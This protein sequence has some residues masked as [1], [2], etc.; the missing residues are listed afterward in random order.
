[1]ILTTQQKIDEYTSKGWWGT[2][3]VL[4]YF[5]TLV[6]SAPNQTAVIDP[7]NKEQLCQSEKQSYTFAQLNDKVNALAAS[8][9]AQGIRKDDI[10][11]VQ[12]PNIAELVVSYLAILKIGAIA[13][14]FP[15]Q[16]REYE[17]THM[18]NALQ[19]KAVITAK[20]ILNREHIQMFIGI[21][22]NTPSVQSIFSVV[23][24]VEHEQ[25]INVSFTDHPKA[26]LE[27]EDYYHKLDMTAN[28]IFT[29][30][31]TSGTEGKPK[32]V[33]RSHNEWFISAYASVDAAKLTKDDTI[34]LTFPLVN[35]A[36]IGGVLIP[37]LLT[38]GTLV[39]HHPFDFKTFLTQLHL[40]KV[41]Y[42]L[43]PPSLLTMMVKD[44][45]LLANLNIEA[46][47]A[48]GTGSAPISTW[49]IDTWKEKHG[50]DLINYFGSNEGA[51][52]LSNI[53]DVPNPEIR[54]KY[55]PR[56]GRQEIQWQNRIA[57]M[58]ESKLVDIDTG[59][60]ITEPNKPGHLKLRGASIFSGYWNAP[61]LNAQVFDEEG[62]FASGDLFE[63]IELDGGPKYYRVAGRLKDII[64]R[65]GMKISPLEVEEM[66]QAMPQVAEVAVVG[67]PDATYGEIACACI[68]PA[69]GQTVTLDDMIAHLTA[70]KISSYKLPEKLV[71]MKEL[72]R[73]A[74]GKI[75]KSELVEEIEKSVLS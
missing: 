50:V 11:A 75:L 38:G 5:E 49:L 53:D 61:E 42:T 28:D 67:C 17:C 39:L 16:F 3:T 68:I 65:G 32:G 72:P 71:I 34:L 44:D 51:T 4:D 47:R 64:V 54:S 19:A 8:L 58:F 6:A 60:E 66:I 37:W 27:L 59:E 14:P 36:G 41:T 10:V 62:Y 70:Q 9:Y 35:M 63:I 57:N 25:V 56:F 29:I 21:L 52:F 45:Q 12:L 26:N 23:G 30:C 69:P 1:M 40:Y 20:H 33:P 15:V 31:W 2:K 13:S 46:L 22:Q 43:V 18:L 73:N 48:I 55:L 74:V 7:E 24:T